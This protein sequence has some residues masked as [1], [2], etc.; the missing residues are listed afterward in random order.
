MRPGEVS[1]GPVLFFSSSS[2][3]PPPPPFSLSVRH[4]FSIAHPHPLLPFQVAPQN[5]PY[6]N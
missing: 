3:S 1:P 6:A 5:T 4:L 2:S